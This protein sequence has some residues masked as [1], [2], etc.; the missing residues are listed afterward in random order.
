MEKRVDTIT[1]L[2]R[3]KFA[4]LMEI[5]GIDQLACFRQDTKLVRD[6]KE[7]QAL[8][9]QGLFELYRDGV[10]SSRGDDYEVRSD[11]A[12]LMNRVKG[13]RVL[14]CAQPAREMRS[15]YYLYGDGD[16]WAVLMPGSRAEEYVRTF[17]FD[18]PIEQFFSE[19]ELLPEDGGQALAL[20]LVDPLTDEMQAHIDV[21][22]GQ[23]GARMVLTQGMELSSQTYSRRKLIELLHKLINEAE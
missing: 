2:S 7:R 21:T 10:L 1:G 5:C 18:R 4:V 14:V 9:N 13:A 6:E 17:L 15:I 12:E 22:D 11:L 3:L 16:K 20:D 8:F 23:E 19:Y